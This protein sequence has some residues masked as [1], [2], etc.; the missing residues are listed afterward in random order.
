MGLKVLTYPLI[1]GNINTDGII[2]SSKYPIEYLELV[3][4]LI[5][6]EATIVPTLTNKSTNINNITLL[7]IFFYYFSTNR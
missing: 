4:V 6:F 7:I 1:L 5:S 3:F 2:T